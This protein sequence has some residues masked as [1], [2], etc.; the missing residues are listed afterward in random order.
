MKKISIVALSILFS[1]VPSHAQDPL[2][3]EQFDAFVEKAMN[4]WRV[5]GLALSII[6]DGRVIYEKGYGMRSLETKEKVTTHTLFSIASATKSFTATAA[7]M[8]ADE[9]RLEWNRPLV[10]YFPGF[11]LFDEAATRKVTITDLLTHRT[12]I[13]RQKF[14][15]INAP[16]TRDEVRYSI[17]FFEPSADFRQA[18]QYF[19]EGYTVAGDMI[20]ELAG[21]SWEQFIRSRIFEKLDMDETVFSVNDLGKE[22]DYATPYITWEEEPERLDLHDACI[23][24]AAGCIISNVDDMSRWLIFNLNHGRI[25][26]ESLVSERNLSVIQSPRMAIQGSPGYR[27]LSYQNYGMGWFIDYYRG[28]LHIHHAGV[29]Y[30]FSSQV[31]FLPSVKV[32]VVILANLNGTKLTEILEWYIYD[33]LLSLDQ[34]DWNGRYLEEWY[35]YRARYKAYTEQMEKDKKPT[36]DL[37]IPL[38]GFVGKFQSQGYGALEI[39]L[40]DDTLKTMMLEYECPFLVSGPDS[41]NLYHPVEHSGWPV[42][43]HANKKGKIDTLM[44]QVNPGV[45]AITFVKTR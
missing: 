13:P 33:K 32:G 37:S 6:R 40:E 11:M 5:P 26:N 14:F 29:L 22:R 7:A 12:G 10:N 3:D 24:G 23:L 31:S 15:S 19:N 35:S 25:G 8:L 30:G 44:V 42:S 43:F 16:A 36:P 18:F 45:K 17:R 20:A 39:Y 4:D 1:V 2:F 38:D 21:S 27:E 9:S 28:C 41:F 34:I